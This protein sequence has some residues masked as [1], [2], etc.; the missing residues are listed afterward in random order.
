MPEYSEKWRNHG[1]YLMTYFEHLQCNFFSLSLLLS[2][3]MKRIGWKQM[4]KR[5]KWLQILY[6]TIFLIFIYSSDFHSDQ[7]NLKFM[8]DDF[9]F[10]LMLIEIFLTRSEISFSVI[11]KSILLLSFMTFFLFCLCVHI[12]NYLFSLLWLFFFFFFFFFFLMKT[13]NLNC[14]IELISL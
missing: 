8:T 9:E 4:K 13:I 11:T 3:E 7:L 1:I 10:V 12:L 14:W 6:N 2:E 5:I